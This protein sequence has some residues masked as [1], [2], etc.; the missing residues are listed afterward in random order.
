MSCN[1]VQILNFNHNI[2]EVGPDNKIV[3]TDQVKCNSITIPQPVTN[4][5]QVNSPGPQGPG[6]SNGRNNYIPLWVGSN[7]LTSSYFNQSGSILKS[8]YNETDIGLKLDFGNNEYLFGTTGS[9]ALDINKFLKF[10]PTGFHLNDGG[11]GLKTRSNTNILEIG[12]IGIDYGQ[13]LLQIDRENSIKTLLNGS[14]IGLKLDFNNNVYTLGDPNGASG[15]TGYLQIQP[16]AGYTLYNLEGYIKGTYIEIGNGGA[17]YPI[18]TLQEGNDLSLTAATIEITG[19]LTVS[20]STPTFKNGATITGSLGVSGSLI[21]SPS[22]SFVLPLS[23]SLSPQVGSAYWSGSLL[24]VYN[25]TRYMSAS[26]A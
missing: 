23:R 25:G 6:L 15:E 1:N 2:I 11:L 24:F 16:G 3:I 20:G 19:L 9:V 12:D 5:L 17:N 7:A 13:M 22:S 4:I 18:I 14:D 21:M 8:T 10:N 26:F